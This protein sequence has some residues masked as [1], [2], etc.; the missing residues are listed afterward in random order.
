[1]CDIVQH[2]CFQEREVSEIQRA[3]LNVEK[4]MKEVV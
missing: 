2:K 1:M 4:T 3:K